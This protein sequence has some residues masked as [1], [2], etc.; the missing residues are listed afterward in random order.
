MTFKENPPFYT[1]CTNKKIKAIIF[2]DSFLISVQPFL[3]EH[4]QKAAYIWKPYD[5]KIIEKLIDIINPDIVIEERTE[6][7][8]NLNSAVDIVMRNA[9]TIK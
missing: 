1:T 7:T 8:L 4:F 9:N 2:R 5:Q 6:R 3:S